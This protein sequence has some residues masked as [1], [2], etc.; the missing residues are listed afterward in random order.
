MLGAFCVV[1]FVPVNFDVLTT[2]SGRAL[3]RFF[4]AFSGVCI[5]LHDSFG[6]LL[7]LLVQTRRLDELFTY[8]RFSFSQLPT[9][10]STPSTNYLASTLHASQLSLTVLITLRHHLKLSNW[11]KPT[12]KTHLLMLIL[13]FILAAS[14]V[15][16]KCTEKSALPATRSTVSPGETSSV[17]RTLLM[18]HVGS[19]KRLSTQMDPMT[20]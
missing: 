4:R 17:S 6:I 15:D 1:T 18:R 3:C 11:P 14:V 13:T 8:P 20:S 9:S 7:R 19:L 12:K 5:A 2:V 10:Y 16:S